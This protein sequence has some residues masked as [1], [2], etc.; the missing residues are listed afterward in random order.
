MQLID[1]ECNAAYFHREN[2]MAHYTKHFT[3]QEALQE[4]PDLKQRFKRILQL[5]EELAARQVETERIQKLIK[6]NG[7]GSN[8]PDFGIQ[9]TELQLQ[10]SEISKR[11]IEIKDISRGLVDFPHW[12]DGEEV[13]LCWLYGEET[14]VYWH[15]IEDGFTGRH[16][17]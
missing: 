11:G 8:H 2:S 17:L 12:R 4:I 13:Y 7:H 10:V 6:S 5:L 3:L 15:R 16:P 9:I 14:I 1:A